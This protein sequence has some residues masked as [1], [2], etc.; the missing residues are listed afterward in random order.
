MLNAHNFRQQVAARKY[1]LLNPRDGVL[2][3]RFEC[4]RCHRDMPDTSYFPLMKADRLDGFGT[5]ARLRGLIVLNGVCLTCRAQQR[6]KWANHPLYSPGLDRHFTVYLRTLRNGAIAR[7][8]FFGLD[9]DDLLGLYIGQ[10]GRCNLTGIRM[11]WESRGKRG[12]GNRALAAPS[13]DRI[14]SG[15][16]YTL[17]NVQMVLQVVNSMK[18]DMPQSTFIEVCQS[19]VN[20]TFSAI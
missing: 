6:G 12:K 2:V 10:E 19:V 7:G 20:H 17:D 14:D 13:V 4:V 11:S 9:K 1:H 15:K 16:D 8:L 3:H 5:K 18:S